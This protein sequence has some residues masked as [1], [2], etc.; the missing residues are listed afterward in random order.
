MASRN[1]HTHFH[2]CL[3]SM[4][5]ASFPFVFGVHENCIILGAYLFHIP[6]IYLE[7]GHL[8][9]LKWV[10]LQNLPLMLQ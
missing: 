7:K 6:Q 10:I 8:E 4:K 2:L 5:T 1:G 9:L 3:V